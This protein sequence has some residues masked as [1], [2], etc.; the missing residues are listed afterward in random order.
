MIVYT[1][2]VFSLL[3]KLVVLILA[4]L[5]YAPIWLAL[6]ADVGVMIIAVL[7]AV[8]VLGKVK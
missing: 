4:A 3:V 6:L 5:G 2:I 7:R 8:S 1:N